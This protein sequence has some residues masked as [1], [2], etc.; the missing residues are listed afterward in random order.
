MHKIRSPI[1]LSLLLGLSILYVITFYEPSA[2]FSNTSTVH[3][4]HRSDPPNDEFTTCLLDAQKTFADLSL[5]WFLAFGTALMYYRS[6]NFVSD[7]ID[8]GIFI[9]DF[10][11]RNITDNDFVSTVRKCGFQLLVR[12]GNMTHGQGWTLECPRSKVHFG[13]FVF[14]PANNETF[15][16]WTASYNGLCNSMRYQKCRWWF[17]DFQPVTFNMYHR[18]FQIVPKQFLIEQYGSR[19]MSPRSYGYSESLTF[20]PNLIKEH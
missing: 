3:L 1:I 19:W 17:S 10:K 12:Y 9:D 20:L 18:H 4:V 7:D 6:N 11:R 15:A 8:I 14:Y 5:P 13:V 16:W 2:I